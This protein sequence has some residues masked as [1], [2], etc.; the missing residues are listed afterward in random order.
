LNQLNS[1]SQFRAYFEQE[2]NELP[3]YYLDMIKK[4]LGPLSA[5]LP[6]GAVFHDQNAY[7]KTMDQRIA[8]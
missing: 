5:W 2:T 7:L 1:D 3:Q 4:D 6:E 8:V